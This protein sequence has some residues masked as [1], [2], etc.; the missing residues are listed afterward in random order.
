MRSSSA[1]TSIP[2]SAVRFIRSPGARC[3]AVAAAL[4]CVPLASAQN[5]QS[6]AAPAAPARGFLE[7]ARDP[8]ATAEQKHTVAA[9]MEFAGET[10]PLKA[11][12]KLKSS[13]VLALYGGG[14]DGLSDLSPLSDLTGLQTLVLFNHRIS[15]L[16]PLENLTNLQT[17]RLE[18]NRI[19]DITPLGKLHKLQSLQ[20][21]DNQI[22]DLRPLSELTQLETLWLSKNQITDISPLR[23]LK[24]L[25]DL[26]LT[27]NKV[28]DLRLFS[29][30]AVSDLRLGGN[31]I[32]DISALRGMNQETPG[33]INLDL[34]NNTI[35]DISP[36]A[37]LGR[38]TSLNLAGN[39]IADI[40]ALDNPALD[41]LDL[42]GNQLT[43]VPDLGKLVGLAHINLKRNPI[44]DHAP[45][46][47]IKKE[48]PRLD[49]AADEAFTHA[50]E[51][52]LPAKKEL[53]GSPLLGEWKSDPIESEW[54]KMLL[55][56]R[57]KENGV[58]YQG[59]L[60][61]EP[62]A[63]GSFSADGRFSVR[64]DRLEMTIQEDTS[65]WRFEVKDDILTLEH[66]G[67]KVRYKKVK[68]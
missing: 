19:R 23:G 59:M 47:A 44:Q 64:G 2:F 3:F 6:P 11:F 41:W 15:D 54:G 36:L 32:T 29:E 65:E 25:R 20:I 10:E 48:R 68:K 24:Q 22:S 56:L 42:E 34:S 14:E 55:E 46:V 26:Y 61:A 7:I 52:S 38:V 53:V 33:F 67:E 31:G 57:F 1:A 60:S 35:R 27:G 4:I 50:F 49:I 62:G 40:A 17:L 5:A 39:Q 28:T 43:R 66:D 37:K 13:D 12:E 51:G 45:L 16:R 8:H 18:A 21:T 30:L 9:L 58:V 63:E